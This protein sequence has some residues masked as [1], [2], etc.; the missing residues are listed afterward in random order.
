MEGEF[1]RDRWC[2]DSTLC[3]PFPSLFALSVDKEVWVTDI[4][5]PLAQG[6]WGGL[7]SLFFKSLQ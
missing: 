7:E 6:G 1:W 2:E 4:W 3:V 5:D